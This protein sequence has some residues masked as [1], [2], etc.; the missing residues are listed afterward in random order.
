MAVVRL[1]PTHA[2]LKEAT[3]HRLI[4]LLYARRRLAILTFPL[5]ALLFAWVEWNQAP[6]RILLA[7]TGAVLAVLL[8]GIA[9]HHRYGRG[10][11]DAAAI[12]EWARWAT[13]NAFLNGC[14]FGSAG[15]FLFPADAV[16]QVFLLLM[17]GGMS[18]TAIASTSSYLPAYNAFVIP[19]LLPAAVRLMAVSDPLHWAMAVLVTVHG[20]FLIGLARIS[21]RTLAEATTLAFENRVLVEDLSEASRELQRLVADRTAELERAREALRQSEEQFRQAQKLEALGRLAGGVAHDFNN[22]LAVILGYAELLLD[23]PGRDPAEQKK[24]VAIRESAEHAAAFTRQL[25]AFSRRNV[26]QPRVVEL[27]AVVRGA[28]RMIRGVVGEEIVVKMTLDPAAGPV[29]VEPDQI[30]QVV[31][32]LVVNARDAIAGR[33]EITIEVAPAELSAEFVA[34]YPGARAG[35]YTLLLVGDTGSGMDEATKGRLFEPFFTTKAMGKGTGLGLSNVYA[36][37]RQNGGFIVV[38]TALGRGTT[39]RI[40]VPQ[41]AAAPAADVPVPAAGR[42]PASGAVLI[43]EDE[44]LVRD[45]VHDALAAAG[46][47]LL[48][49]DGPGEALALSARHP[50]PIRLMVTDMRMPAMTGLELAGKLGGTRPDMRVLFIS[51]YVDLANDDA[52]A[53]AV[54]GRFLQKPF[55]PSELVRKV[56][57]VLAAA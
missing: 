22:A 5:V 52:T 46:F 31:T 20:G 35:P 41:S 2:T 12:R 17:L 47:T 15:Y 11:H 39:F 50:G 42:A 16:H 26:H 56:D 34:P 33:G 8:W 53:G 40:Y 1:S 32:N 9:L 21:H 7:W 3:L 29:N 49:A 28:E 36:I 6:E 24:L 18:S 19:M 27:A 43:V 10:T 44:P 25:L 13:L 37:V 51:G 45:M 14:V 4:E 54:A 30:V 38:E 48:V 23:A 57:E 55:L